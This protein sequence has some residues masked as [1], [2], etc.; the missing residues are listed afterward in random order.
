MSHGTYE[1]VITMADVDM[2]QIFYARLVA[3]MGDGFEGLFRVL[4]HPLEGELAA[5]RGAPVVGA[6]CEYMKPVT[7]GD[8]I[9]LK[10][11][12]YRAGGASFTVAHRFERDGQLVAVGHVEHVWVTMNPA[13]RPLRVPDWLRNSHEPNFLAGFTSRARPIGSGTAASQSGIPS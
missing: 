7:L 9:T 3:M 12:L 2:V 1:R 10:S 8:R 4:G 13:Q 5:G 11:A 6:H